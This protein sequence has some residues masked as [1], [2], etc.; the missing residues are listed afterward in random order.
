MSARFT[1]TV[2]ALA[3]LASMTLA[4]AGCVERTISIT[5]EPSGALVYLNDDEIGRT[6][7]TVPF[8][9]Y[10]VYDIRLEA[11]GYQPLWTK[12]SADAPLWEYPGPDLIG[13]MVPNNRVEFN[14][15]FKLDPAVQ[16]EPNEV[17]DRAK[18]LRATLRPK[19]AETQPSDSP[20]VASDASR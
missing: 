1:G 13:E 12:E 4:L 6:P 11:E 7:V 5:S 19:P 14:W 20:A 17:I 9:Y 3:V 10:G 8:R 2:L 15:H 16:H 18:Q